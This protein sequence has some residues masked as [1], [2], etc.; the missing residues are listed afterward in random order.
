[1][2]QATL[3]RVTPWDIAHG[4]PRNCHEC[5]AA[6]AIIR[7]LGDLLPEG[8]VVAVGGY[9][10]VVFLPDSEIWAPLPQSAGNFI[11]AL[12]E[13]GDPGAPFEFTLTW[14]RGQGRRS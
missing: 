2:E 1:M 9:R 7:A 3:V 10:A 12:D 4:K 8:S 6:L 14:R 13:L 5:P 11:G